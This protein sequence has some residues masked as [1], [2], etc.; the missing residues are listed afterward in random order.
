M[1]KAIIRIIMGG[2]MILGLVVLAS[3]C[4]EESEL[5]YADSFTEGI[6]LGINEGNYAQSSEH[7]DEDLKDAMPE[8]TFARIAPYVKEVIG[9]YIPETKE[10]WHVGTSGI[11]T[12]VYYMAEYT[13]QA[14]DVI[15]HVGFHESEGK[16]YVY[17]FWFEAS[18]LWEIWPLNSMYQFL[19]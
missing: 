2:V 6:L 10:L 9:N 11:Y 19:Y 15:V 8:V 14:R 18:Y 12:D 1:Q 13:K 4:S 5:E 17:G 16:M 3:S 7:F